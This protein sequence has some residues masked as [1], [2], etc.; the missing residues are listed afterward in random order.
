VCSSKFNPCFL[1]NIRRDASPTNG[2]IPNAKYF[3]VVGECLPNAG[4]K[5]C[6]CLL[7]GNG[8]LHRLDV[9]YIVEI[10]DAEPQQE[11]R[12]HQ[13][14]I[15]N[16]SV[17]ARPVAPDEF[18]C[19]EAWPQREVFECPEKLSIETGD[20]LPDVFPRIFETNGFY[21]ERLTTV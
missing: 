3:Q 1:K 11:H 16:G 13:Q 5:L 19:R 20:V 14:V 6:I 21:L 15:T 2:T 17:V 12:D 9:G 10:D 8:S 7:D 4:S 18:A